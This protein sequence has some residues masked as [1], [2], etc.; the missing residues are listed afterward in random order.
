MRTCVKLCHLQIYRCVNEIFTLR[1]FLLKN[2][3]RDVVDEFN[4]SGMQ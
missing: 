4:S 1:V 3:H 2:I